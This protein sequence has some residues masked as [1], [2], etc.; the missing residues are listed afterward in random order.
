MVEPKEI[1]KA[2]LGL[3]IN[4]VHMPQY[5]CH[6]RVWAL[7]IKDVALHPEIRMSGIV[8]H[9]AYV[10]ITFVNGNFSPLNWDATFPGVS[11]P[12]PGWY[13]VVYEDGYR[14]FSPGESFET[15]YTLVNKPQTFLE[16]AKEL[17][18]S[19][20]MSDAVQAPID[21]TNVNK[22]LKNMSTETKKAAPTDIEME[23]MHSIFDD[24]NGVLPATKYKIA[25]Y[26][27]KVVGGKGYTFR[28]LYFEALV[29]ARIYGS[30]EFMEHDTHILISILISIDT[31]GSH[32]RL[33][34]RYFEGGVSHIKETDYVIAIASSMNAAE[35]ICK[36][37]W[38]L[39][40]VEIEQF[41]STERK[42]ATD[43]SVT[44]PAIEQAQD[45][46]QKAQQAKITGYRT[47]SVD[48]IDLMN[49]VK[50]EGIVIGDL[51]NKLQGIGTLDQRWVSIGK[52]DLQTGLMALTRAIAQP[53]TF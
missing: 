47:L 50:A 20:R 46:E 32:V 16:E 33:N 3:H 25:S 27:N 29:D 7:K 31:D 35:E 10:V 2:G 34:T 49:Q 40:E 53:T 36:K 12:K 24:L 45:L 21:E 14:S 15:G 17:L 11:E 5:Q 6:K 26:L 13:Y 51:V 38:D 37:L 23:R 22:E 44:N 8:Q 39:S 18:H 48:E 52:T 42:K 43:C 28:D 4:G 41:E 19:T 30:L 1:S 9:K